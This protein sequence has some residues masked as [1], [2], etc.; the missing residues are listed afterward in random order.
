MQADFRFT[1]DGLL[2]GSN[3]SG[4]SD[5]QRSSVQVFRTGIVEAV[6]SNLANRGTIILPKIET[7]IV[8][9][10]RTYAA[11]LQRFGVEPPFAVAVSLVGVKG[12]TLLQ[13]Y[14]DSAFMEDVPRAILARDQLDFVEVLF[15]TVPQGSQDC[16]RQLRA[17]LDHMANAA[18]L[19]ASC[20]FDEDGNYTLLRDAPP[21]GTSL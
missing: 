13:D 4:L 11:S 6:A 15:E 16:A 7:S 9:K 3:L 2:T 1:F 10:A 19:P 8:Q 14:L 21:R 18:G 20:H 5:T 12:L 17:T